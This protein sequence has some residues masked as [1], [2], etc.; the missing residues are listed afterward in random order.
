MSAVAVVESAGGQ[1]S[2]PT[3]P[4]ADLVGRGMKAQGGRERWGREDLAP[5]TTVQDQH[6]QGHLA[7]GR[8]GL[9]GGHSCP[10]KRASSPRADPLRGASFPILLKGALCQGESKS[11]VRGPT[12]SSGIL[13]K[14]GPHSWTPPLSK[15]G[16][17]RRP[18][19]PFHRVHSLL[20][21]TPN[22]TRPN[23]SCAST[24]TATFSAMLSLLRDSLGL[25][26]QR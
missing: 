21:S 13:C 5:Q 26:L 22:A 2:W 17:D 19:Q 20:P 16:S 14:F 10:A 1:G 23:P 9:R 15:V 6:V 8:W 7:W 18:L 12:P 24:P 3:R 25:A 4:K 11:W